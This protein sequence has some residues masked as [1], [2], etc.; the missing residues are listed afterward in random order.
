MR[1]VFSAYPAADALVELHRGLALAVHL[2]LARPGAAAHAD[3]LQTAAEAGGS[4]ALKVAQGDEHIRVH[5]GPADLGLPDIFAPGH[6]DIAL[7]CALQ[8]VGDD[9]LAAGGEGGKAVF[10]GG[11]QM[12]Q[13]VL[14][15]AHIK[16][17]GVGQKGLAPQLLHQVGHRLGVLGPEIGHVAR[18]AHMQLDA[19]ELFVEIDPFDARRDEQ[20]AQF[21]GNIFSLA[22]KIG[23]INLGCHRAAPFLYSDGSTIAYFPAADKPLE[24]APGACFYTLSKNFICSSIMVRISLPTGVVRGSR[25]YWR[26]VCS[27]K[28]TMMSVPS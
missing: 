7:V 15:A 10:I 18:L 22:G 16:G 9:H 2:H 19:G 17:V 6:G 12:L 5:K 8:A 3:V 20:A 13:G 14:P 1:A 25:W 28:G 11:V 27:L 24:Q 26:K 21:F 23:K 4:V